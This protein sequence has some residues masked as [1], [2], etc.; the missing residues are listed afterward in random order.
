MVTRLLYSDLFLDFT[1]ST[2]TFP[3]IAGTAAIILNYYKGAYEAIYGPNHYEAVTTDPIIDTEE[4]KSKIKSMVSLLVYN[5][6]SRKELGRDGPTVEE[7]Y[8]LATLKSLSL[9]FASRED[10]DLVET[11]D[12]VE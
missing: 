2:T 7:K 6:A 10:T 3:T 5:L 4:C 9:R 1:L 11:G 8:E 12:N